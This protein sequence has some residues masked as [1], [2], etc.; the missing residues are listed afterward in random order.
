M[1]PVDKWLAILASLLSPAYPGPVQV[2]LDEQIR[3]HL[4]DSFSDAVYTPESARLVAAA[5]RFGAVPAW[6]VIAKVLRQYH[7][8]IRPINAGLLPAP[9]E[10]DRVQPGPDEIQRIDDMIAELKV[11]KASNPGPQRT[12]PDG[13]PLPDVSFSGD[14]LQHLREQTRLFSPFLHKP[15]IWA[16]ADYQSELLSVTA[17]LETHP[18]SKVLA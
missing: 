14:R 4:R 3:P 11:W 13:K 5:K 16:K 2:A 9:R 18:K 8:D 15:D 10:P 12:R 1:E 6:D 7:R 17:P